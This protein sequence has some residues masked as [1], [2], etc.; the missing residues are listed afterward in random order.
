[1]LLAAVIVVSSDTASVRD[2]ASVASSC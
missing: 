2:V 1:M